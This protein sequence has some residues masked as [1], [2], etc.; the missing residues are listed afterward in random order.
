MT[1][2]CCFSGASFIKYHPIEYRSAYRAHFYDFKEPLFAWSKMI[3]QKRLVNF[4]FFNCIWFV[5]YIFYHHDRSSICAQLFSTNKIITGWN[6]IRQ[7]F[8]TIYFK[9]DTKNC[10]KE[11][12]VSV[13]CMF[14]LVPALGPKKRL[15]T[16][17][18]PWL[19]TV[20]QQLF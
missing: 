19:C 12:A 13:Q 10:L 9:Y 14:M 4:T 1:S 17:A 20:L 8:K 6:S 7:V 3:F 2:F 5:A 15:D 11:S 16:L 18:A